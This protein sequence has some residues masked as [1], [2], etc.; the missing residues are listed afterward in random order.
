MKY[1]RIF[2]HL[3]KLDKLTQ[4]FRWNF[5]NENWVIVVLFRTYITMPEGVSG[6]FVSSIKALIKYI[7]T[8][9]TF[10]FNY[11]FH[12]LNTLFSWNLKSVGTKQ[13]SVKKKLFCN[14]NFLR[15]YFNTFLTKPPL[16]SAHIKIRNTKKDNF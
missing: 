10:F 11:W 4:H 14:Y 15:V 9:S 16:L 8:I 6:I 7:F 2:K 5:R 1:S 12:S 13:L 3:F